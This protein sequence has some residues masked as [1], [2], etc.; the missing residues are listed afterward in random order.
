MRAVYDDIISV[1]WTTSQS[2]WC[3]QTT[4]LPHSCT[5]TTSCIH[6]CWIVMQKALAAVRIPEWSSKS[7]VASHG[8]NGKWAHTETVIC[9]LLS[10][11]RPVVQG[12]S[13]RLSGPRGR[14]PHH[15]CTQCKQNA[16]VHASNGWLLM[17]GV[18]YSAQRIPREPALLPSASMR[19]PQLHSDSAVHGTA[20]PAHLKALPQHRASP[21]LW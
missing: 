15:G 17:E 7:T 14:V 18:K 9:L 19:N 4:G 21:V 6:G 11:C 12:A 16:R 20:A 2:Q 10:G 3:K 1:S 5:A 8:G 13:Q